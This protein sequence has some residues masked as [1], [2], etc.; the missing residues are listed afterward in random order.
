MGAAA[1]EAAQ[2]GGEVAL[3]VASAIVRVTKPTWNIKKR[4]RGTAENKLGAAEAEAA[5]AHPTSP[6]S[7]GFCAIWY[8]NPHGGARHA[9]HIEL[10]RGCCP[11]AYL[12]SQAI[13]MLVRAVRGRST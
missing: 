6:R 8:C 13:A 1:E 4:L 11:A 5:H 9:G 2:P 12:V 3:G 7:T 10:G